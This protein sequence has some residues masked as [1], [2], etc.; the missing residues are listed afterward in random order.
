M[1]IQPVDRNILVRFHKPQN[2]RIVS[3]GSLDTSATSTTR[4]LIEVLA[5][6]EA[7][8]VPVKTGDFILIPPKFNVIPIDGEETGIIHD[9]IIIGIVTDDKKPE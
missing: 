8:K 3:V 2:S 6:G 5:V 1:Q 9:S 7:V 4:I